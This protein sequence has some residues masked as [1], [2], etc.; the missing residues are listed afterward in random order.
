MGKKRPCL[1]PMGFYL[2]KWDFFLKT[3]GFFFGKTQ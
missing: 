1:K 2:K 3:I